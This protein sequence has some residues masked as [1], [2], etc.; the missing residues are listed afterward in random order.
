[1]FRTLLRTLPSISGNVKLNCNLDL[2]YTYNNKVIYAKVEKAFLAVAD[3]DKNSYVYNVN[4]LNSRW[5]YDVSKFY[6]F[7][8]NIFFSSQFAF[9]KNDCQ[10]LNRYDT[11]KQRDTDFE[12]GVSRIQ[13]KVYG[14]QLSFF[15]PIYVDNI[16]DLPNQFEIDL[17]YTHNDRE[18]T[19]KIIVPIRPE[20]YTGLYDTDNQ[21]YNYLYRYVKDVDSKIVFLNNGKIKYYGINLLKGGLTESESPS[22]AMQL[23]NRFYPI[24]KVDSLITSG[25]QQLKMCSKQILPLAFNFDLNDLFS[26]VEVG[27]IFL[28]E[29][30]IYGG[31]K[32]TDN[33]RH[34]LKN[35]T[36]PIYDFFIDPDKLY[37]DYLTV[38][39]TNLKLKLG[40]DKNLNLLDS[41]EPGLHES[42]FYK[43]QFSNRISPN[44]TKWRI[45]KSNLENDSVFDSQDYLINFNN[46]FDKHQDYFLTQL[47]NYSLKNISGSCSNLALTDN[48]S[49]NNLVLPT[50]SYSYIDIENEN[51]HKSYSNSYYDNSDTLMYWENLSNGLYHHFNLIYPSKE[52]LSYS[53]SYFSYS[54]WIQNNINNIIE[55]CDFV[56]DNGFDT[57]IF[58]KKNSKYN[59][60]WHVPVN[61]SVLYNGILYDFSSLECA[62]YSKYLTDIDN[63]SKYLSISYNN[64]IIDYLNYNNYDNWKKTQKITKFGAFILPLPSIN[65]KNDIYTVQNTFST[66]TDGVSVNVTNDDLSNTYNPYFDIDDSKG[67]YFS[68]EFNQ[69]YGRTETTFNEI[70]FEAKSYYDINYN[71]YYFNFSDFNDNV[72][73]SYMESIKKYYSNEYTFVSNIVADNVMSYVKDINDLV[74][75]SNEF[76]SL[77]SVDIDNTIGVSY[78]CVFDFEKLKLKLE[79]D[80][81]KKEEFLSYVEIAENGLKFFDEQIYESLYDNCKDYFS[82]TATLY[83][84]FVFMGDDELK[85]NYLRSI[86]QNISSMIENAYVLIGETNIKKLVSDSSRILNCSCVLNNLYTKNDGEDSEYQQVRFRN[87]NNIIDASININNAKLYFKVDLCLKD[88]IKDVIQQIDVNLTDTK[89][90]NI[91]KSSKTEDE[92]ILMNEECQ[93]KFQKIFD[94]LI[95]D[96]GKNIVWLFGIDDSSSLTIDYQK[97]RKNIGTY[98]VDRVFKMTKKYLNNLRIEYDNQITKLVSEQTRIKSSFDLVGSIVTDV[99]TSEEYYNFTPVLQINKS[100]IGENVFVMEVKESDRDFLGEPNLCWVDTLNIK[101]SSLL[102]TPKKF[103]SMFLSKSH[104]KRYIELM[105]S[106]P[107]GLKVYQKNNLSNSKSIN[108][109]EW[110][111]IKLNQT[112]V[113]GNETYVGGPFYNLFI[114]EKHL[115]Y[116][117]ALNTYISKYKYTSF[118][119]WLKKKIIEKYP[120]TSAGE[121]IE[122]KIWNDIDIDK[123]YECLTYEYDEVDKVNKFSFK[124]TFDNYL[125]NNIEIEETGLCITYKGDFIPLSA[126]QME[127][128]YQIFDSNGELKNDIVYNTTKKNYFIN[129]LYSNYD[130]DRN[131]SFNR[132]NIIIN[133]NECGS[134]SDWSSIGV[135]CP[136]YDSSMTDLYHITIRESLMNNIKS[137][138]HDG[139]N[140]YK[141]DADYNYNN[142]VQLTESVWNNIK[143]LINQT[144]ISLDLSQI[145]I[146]I[147]YDEEKVLIFPEYNVKSK[148]DEFNLLSQHKLYTY[149]EDGENYGFYLIPI[150]VS[151]NIISNLYA[152]TDPDSGVKTKTNKFLSVNNVPLINVE[153]NTLNINVDGALNMCSETINLLNYNTNIINDIL[154][155]LT[156]RKNTESINILNNLYAKKL[157][158]TLNTSEY[159]IFE[160]DEL[161]H[162]INLN[163]YLHY[164]EPAFQKVNTEKLDYIYNI[165]F[166][167]TN[168]VV[169]SKSIYNSIGDTPIESLSYIKHHINVYGY[170]ASSESY[171]DNLNLSYSKVINNLYYNNIIDQFT[172]YEYHDFDYNKYFILPHKLVFPLE[173]KY[174]YESLSTICND[175]TRLN[176]FIKY[177]EDFK[178]IS[179][180][181]LILFLYRCYN[182]NLEFIADGLDEYSSKKVYTGRFV[183]TLK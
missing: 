126:I 15:A 117:D 32:Y 7:Y 11:I 90:T 10:K 43:Y 127:D 156:L 64:N 149:Y 102:D 121:F 60:F 83:T 132:S 37:I 134:E 129:Y 20:N 30:S 161:T 107:N 110:I 166:K 65:V 17:K 105:C 141:I 93:T 109:K 35:V 69:K 63:R 152:E 8:S 183:L 162:T 74:K 59:T 29:I 146:Y 18:I 125:G 159:D 78:N 172:P 119:E 142:F 122:Q 97:Y 168:N 108:T 72:L 151:S 58:D 160:T 176:R 6:S 171:Y 135:L 67:N 88:E 33:D 9:D 174:D 153:Q 113:I 36:L 22:I 13:Y 158:T 76:S 49:I 165:K 92:T 104:I 154:S 124:Y 44:Y 66:S 99:I 23:N 73:C 163:R 57:S 48:V 86:K 101:D 173:K 14:K 96:N 2:D 118:A 56:S 120:N 39:R 100:E 177:C 143:K 19:K 155:N 178:G 77:I 85:N 175:D 128:E 81:V 61:D 28:N 169:T 16:L 40:T 157:N 94:W 145:P 70:D 114:V 55:N 75:K 68:I 137:F 180:R 1:M 87:K 51:R 41:D 131:N 111:S 21:F 123:F 27:K 71:S 12:F 26:S 106:S 42:N 50:Y 25:F 53:I 138:K 170:G 46:L 47:Q 181:N 139:E 150:K 82:K 24:Q 89:I 52:Y 103:Y 34:E 148:Y 164:V 144:G 80:T 38:D 54:D 95:K 31:Y 179:D 115:V 5:D 140:Y 62:S 84:P 3:H 91:L 4:L 133:K 79:S 98:L 45:Q 112:Y 167:N 130:F 136:I 147:K 182:S 116:D